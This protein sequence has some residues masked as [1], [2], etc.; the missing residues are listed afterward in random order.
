ALASVGA[1]G[2][3]LHAACHEGS[4]C[5]R[6]AHP[7][8]EVT[9]RPLLQEDVEPLKTVW[10]V[11]HVSSSCESPSLE[12]AEPDELTNAAGLAGIMW[13]AST[14]RQNLGQ[15]GPMDDFAPLRLT[16]IMSAGIGSVSAGA[17]QRRRGLR[18]PKRLA[19]STTMKMQTPDRKTSQTECVKYC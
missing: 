8:D 13:P 19:A 15:A 6:A 16:P 17:G 18:L 11:T 9:A 2:E 3:E 4:E 7:A 12:G 1:G 5:C 10:A 14:R